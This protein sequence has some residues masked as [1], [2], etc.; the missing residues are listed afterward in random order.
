MFSDQWNYGKRIAIS[1]G[2]LALMSGGV[3]AQSLAELRG[4]AE[5]SQDV[6]TYGSG[7]G[8]QRHSRLDLKRQQHGHF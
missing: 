3:W 1:L 4:D 7:W 2:I 5:S 8:Q 6:L